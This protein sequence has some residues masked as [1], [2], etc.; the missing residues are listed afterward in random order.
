MLRLD[1]EARYPAELTDPRGSRGGNVWQHLRTF[2]KY[3]FDAIRMEDLKLDGEWID[4]ANDW[5]YMLPIVEMSTRPVH[6]PEPLYIYDPSPR[7]RESYLKE[8]DANI[9][10]IVARLRYTRLHPEEPDSGSRRLGK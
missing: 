3:L 10:R 4:C 5:A 1:K 6:I 8:R 7:E 9:S 2:R